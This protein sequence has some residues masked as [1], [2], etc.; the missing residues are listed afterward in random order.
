MVT[1]QGM[2]PPPTQVTRELGFHVSIRANR[3]GSVFTT[4]WAEES[5]Y[6]KKKRA[7]RF[8]KGI[9]LL[10]EKKGRLV[11]TCTL[12]WF[13]VAPKLPRCFT[14]VHKEPPSPPPPRHLAFAYP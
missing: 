3:Y 6:W 7:I 5:I 12:L 2:S 9:D 10:E 4:S 14:V 1:R 11:I 8:L 13:Q